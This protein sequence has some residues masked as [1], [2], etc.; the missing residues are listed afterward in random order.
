M[1][2]CRCDVGCFLLE[3]VVNGHL[4][5]ICLNNNKPSLLG[6]SISN[7][8]M[9]DIP[10]EDRGARLDVELCPGEQHVRGVGV[11]VCW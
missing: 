7:S 2:N 4:N 5:C 6:L 3:L 10:T 1:V 8:L 9:I 11:G